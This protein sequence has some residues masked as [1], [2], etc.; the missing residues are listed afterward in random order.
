MFR[1]HIINKDTVTATSLYKQNEKNSEIY[2]Y[3]SV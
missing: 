1:Y 3:E 2:P